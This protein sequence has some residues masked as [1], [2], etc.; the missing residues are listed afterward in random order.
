MPSINQL[1]RSDGAFVS[2]RPYILLLFRPYRA[3]EMDYDPLKI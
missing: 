1:F 2:Y 3:K